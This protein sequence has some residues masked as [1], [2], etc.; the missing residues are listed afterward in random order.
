MG[1]GWIVGDDEGVREGFEV[2]VM[3]LATKETVD[4]YVTSVSLFWVKSVKGGRGKLVEV[5]VVGIG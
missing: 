3:G 4:G 1:E 2:E 5:F